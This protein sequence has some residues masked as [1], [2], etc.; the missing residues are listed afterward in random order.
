MRVK[1]KAE[2]DLILALLLGLH[3]DTAN[4]IKTVL[5]IPYDLGLFHFY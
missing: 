2:V 5:S 3:I 4:T 1:F